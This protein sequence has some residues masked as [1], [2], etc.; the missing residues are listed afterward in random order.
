MKSELERTCMTEWLEKNVKR[1]I[2][3]RRVTARVGMKGLEG[4]TTKRQKGEM[5]VADNGIRMPRM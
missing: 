3:D 2:C 5:E 1:V 4:G